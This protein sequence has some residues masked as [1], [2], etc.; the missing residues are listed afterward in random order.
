MEKPGEER[1]DAAEDE[2]TGLPGFRSWKGVYLFVAAVFIAYLLF[3]T[4]FSRMFS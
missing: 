2:S 1:P 3:L 4:L